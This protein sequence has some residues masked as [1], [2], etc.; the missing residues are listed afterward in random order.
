MTD[1]KRLERLD[2]L[3]E[4]STRIG[5]CFGDADKIFAGHTLDENRAKEFRKLALKNEI[6]LAEVQNIVSGYL[7][8]TGFF[9][10][11]CKEQTDKATKFFGMKL[12]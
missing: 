3:E 1:K 9:L 4:I 11:H 12:K 6:T 5:G 10:E 2:A 8:R 7:Y